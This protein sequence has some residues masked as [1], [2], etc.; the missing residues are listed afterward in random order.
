MEPYLEGEFGSPASFHQGGLRAR[1]A[2]APGSG[3]VA[4]LIGAESP[5]SILFTSGATESANLA[6]KGAAWASHRRGN[7]VVLTWNRTSG[8]RTFG[9]TFWKGRDYVVTRVP[10]DRRVRGSRSSRDRL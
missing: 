7:H 10:V 5:D 3:E 6:V 4:A 1:D 2:L 9:G 8:H